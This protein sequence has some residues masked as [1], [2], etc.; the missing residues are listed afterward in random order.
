MWC[1][2]FC[3]WNRPSPCRCCGDYDSSWTTTWLDGVMFQYTAFTCASHMLLLPDCGRAAVMPRHIPRNTTLNLPVTDSMKQEQG[4]VIHFNLLLWPSSGLSSEVINYFKYLVEGRRI[5]NQYIGGMLEQRKLW[6]GLYINVPKW[7]QNLE[8]S[9]RIVQ[10]GKRLGNPVTL[11]TN[12]KSYHSSRNYIIYYQSTGPS[13][14]FF[15]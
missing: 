12:S 9:I 10:D 14:P 13:N 2:D 8:P 1:M 6:I 15:V 5:T 7:H 11:L 4:K 3:E